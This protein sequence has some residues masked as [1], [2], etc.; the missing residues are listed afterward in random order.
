MIIQATKC[1]PV[2]VLGCALAGLL[3]LP[4]ADAPEA[5]KGGILLVIDGT[6]KEQKIKAWKFSQGTRHLTWLAPAQKPGPEPKE[7]KDPKD[8]DKK[9]PPAK[10]PIKGRP[11]IGPEA[12]EFRDEQSTTYV[13][14]ILTLVPLEHIRSLEYDDNKQLVTLKVAAAGGDETLTGTTKYRGINKLSIEAEVD[15]GDMGIAEV[16]FLGGVPKGIRSVTFPAPKAAPAGAAGRPATVTVA[17]KQKIVQKAHD[18]QPLYRMPDGSEKLLPMIMF[19]KTL[20]V[21][22]A[23]VQ[24]LHLVEGSKGEEVEW[25]VT[26]KDGEEQTLTLLK[27]ITVDE[28]PAV[29]QGFLGRVPAG[30]KLFP[31]HTI[32]A[33]V[34]DE[35]KPD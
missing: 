19:K 26:F 21:E 14:G 4:A 30:Y 25:M 17:D 28:K 5:G 27:T 3:S 1:W 24:K 23:K 7:E 32:S 13:D 29:L 6:G 10:A 12:L 15:K 35:A 33:I 20:K 34:F 9:A 31:A 16:K 22:L 8:N 2:L 11:S 18:L